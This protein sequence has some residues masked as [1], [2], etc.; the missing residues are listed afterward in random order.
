MRM[1]KTPPAAALSMLLTP[2]AMLLI[3][4]TLIGM[5]FPLGKLAGEAGVS[6][7]VWAGLISLGVVIVLLPVQLATRGL[8]LPPGNILLYTLISAVISFVV[9]NLLLF[10]VIPQ[11]GAG[12]SGLMFA[13]SPVFTL[14]FAT[15]TGMKTPGRLGLTGIA[16]GLL[17]ATIVSLTREADA[18][19]PETRWLLAAASIPVALALGN[20]FRSRYWPEGAAPN[21]LAFWGHVFAGGLFLLLLLATRGELPLNEIRPVSTIVIAQMLI[22]GLNFPFFYRLQ[23]D[24]GPVLLSQIGYVAAAVGLIAATVFLGE[25]YS[26]MTW[27]GAGI[28]SV[29]IAITVVAQRAR[30][31]MGAKQ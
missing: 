26:L 29:G 21:M 23:R 7:L 25:R 3:S 18:Q 9:P 8:R 30:A 24:G 19:G 31:S 1:L 10:S 2:H 12:Y 13:L 6:P 20:V 27:L 14:M 16:I 5:N 11:V 22:S 17:G 4:G 28:I 15:L